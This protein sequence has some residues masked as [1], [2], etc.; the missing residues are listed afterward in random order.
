MLHVLYGVTV[1][2]ADGRRT[3]HLTDLKMNEL[4]KH[5]LFQ[6]GLSAGKMKVNPG[7]RGETEDACGILREADGMRDPQGPV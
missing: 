5:L 1:R 4:S 3:H 2:M 6:V 7:G